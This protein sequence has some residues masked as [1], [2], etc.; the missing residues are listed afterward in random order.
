M[1]K[2]AL[3]RRS[4]S[5]VGGAELYL[6]R[7]LQALAARGHA[8]HLLTESWSQPPAEVSLHPL[9]VP[10]S[11][12]QR[13]WAFARAVDQH[14][15][16]SSYDCV[17]SLER[18]LHQDVYRAGDGVHR[19]WLERRRQF[20]PW[21]RKFWTGRFHRAMVAL[22][23]ETLHPDHTRF[24]IV[25]SEMVRAEIQRCFGF[26][27]ER[28]VLVRNGIEVSRFQN[29]H[30]EETRVKYGIGPEDFVCLFVGSGWERKGLRFVVDAFRMAERELKERC[31]RQLKLLVA[32]KG[33]PFRGG[34]NIIF[35]GSVPDVE[36]LYAAADLLTFVPIY[37]PSANVCVEALAAGVPILTSRFNGAAELIT[38][39]TLGRV[40]DD[41]ADARTIS[42]E[43]LLRASA[44]ERIRA[45]ADPE[46]LSLERNVRETLTVLEKA[47]RAR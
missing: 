42:T 23:K 4:F 19:V 16:G 27:S 32:G 6:Q 20:G 22:E 2:L 17:F 13:P 24:V 10:G 47:A 9:A 34:A 30:R 18:T 44:P 33:R 7:L 41:P 5:P 28:I 3:V 11:R 37:E 25:N 29:G 15:R 35:A 40:I 14:L 39:S 12:A 8:I 1:M 26:P 43:I 21:W 38:Q 31:G 46:A 36:N 45:S